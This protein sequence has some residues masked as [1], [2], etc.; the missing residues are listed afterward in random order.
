[1]HGSYIP[2]RSLRLCESLITRGIFFLAKPLRA[3]RPASPRGAFAFSVPLRET[4]FSLSR[5]DR[6]DLYTPAG[7]CDLRAFA[8]G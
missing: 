1:M 6:K 4:F 8:R 5:K 7:I 3:Q 2:L